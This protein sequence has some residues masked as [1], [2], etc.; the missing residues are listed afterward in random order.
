M[1]L[2]AAQKTAIS[3]A[4]RTYLGTPWR[5]QGRDHMGID[6]VGIVVCSL[7]DIGLEVD[8]PTPPVYRNIDSKLLMDLL[9]KHCD[10]V[11]QAD[12]QVGDIVVFGV[13]WEAHIALLVDGAPLNAIHCPMGGRVVEA[14]FDRNR[15]IIRGFYRWRSLQLA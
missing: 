15:G 7:R 14:R 5:G 9:R 3:A 12:P 1:P 6:C 10:R 2:T 8:E 11:S 4:A 13:P